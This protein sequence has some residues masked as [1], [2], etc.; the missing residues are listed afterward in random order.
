MEGGTVGVQGWGPEPALSRAWNAP[1]P[2]VP[3]L[4]AV[5]CGLARQ[6]A[7]RAAV[8]PFL[9]PP[10]ACLAALKVSKWHPVDCRDSASLPRNRPEKRERAQA[11]EPGGQRAERRRRMDPLPLSL[12]RSLDFCLCS[13]RL[14]APRGLW[15]GF[16][17]FRYYSGKYIL[18]QEYFLKFSL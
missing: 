10:S 6:S 12:K 4:A 8:S 7:S 3:I 15:L 18:S 9:Q 17:V 1:L 13:Q 5:A 2:P 14:A 11:A 16:P